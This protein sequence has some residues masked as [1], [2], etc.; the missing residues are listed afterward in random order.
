MTMI[1]PSMLSNTNLLLVF[2]A[3]NC[4]SSEDIEKNK[5]GPWFNGDQRPFEELETMVTNYNSYFF[6]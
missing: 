4:L 3:S 5:S 2:Y 1:Y 6:S